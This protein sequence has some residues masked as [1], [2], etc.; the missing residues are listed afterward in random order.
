MVDVE[1]PRN[2]PAGQRSTELT[3]T[4]LDE[5]NGLMRPESRG[6]GLTVQGETGCSPFGNTVSHD[7]RRKRG[8]INNQSAT[9]NIIYQAGGSVR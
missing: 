7:G 1:S 4:G 5:P 2:R 9:V 8:G 3:G 6:H